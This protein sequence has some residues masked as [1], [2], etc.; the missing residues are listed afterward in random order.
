ML[1]IGDVLL[2]VLSQIWYFIPIIIAIGLFKNYVN[3]KEKATRQ[4]RNK[5]RQKEFYANNEKKGQEFELRTGRKFEELGYKVVYNG[6]EKGRKDEG[7]DLLCYKDNKILL[8][9]CKNYSKPKSVT[10]EHIKIFHSNAIKYVKTNQIKNK[11]V[12]F[13]YAIPNKNVLDISAIKILMNNFY[14]CRYI[15]II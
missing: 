12:E 2:G 13:K 8:V 1:N 14:N 11:N 3:K 10:H 5:K 15:E 7:I 4:N 6:I 9:Q